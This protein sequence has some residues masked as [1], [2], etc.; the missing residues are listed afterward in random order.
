MHRIITTIAI[1]TGLFVTASAVAGPAE[2]IKAR[3]PQIDKL[4]KSGK[5]G[6]N[7]KGFLEARSSVSS[8]E[9][10][11]IAD[12]NRDRKALYTQVAK[13]RGLT[14]DRVGKLR[15]T[16]IY[17]KAKGGIHVQTAGGK[18]VKK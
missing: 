13:K 10:K 1:A 8:A 16:D 5:A 14:M 11:L 12:E 3:V 2:N 6:E 9:K 7:N 15:A 17:N 18:W 4:L